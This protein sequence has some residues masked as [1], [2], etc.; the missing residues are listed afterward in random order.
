MKY[1]LFA[2]PSAWRKTAVGSLKPDKGGG[3]RKNAEKF[4]VAYDWTRDLPIL[5]RAMVLLKDKL[6]VAGPPNLWNE[7]TVWNHYRRANS[8]NDAA[9]EQDAAM[10]GLK[11]GTM[12]V[13]SAENG[14]KICES[15]LSSPPAWDGMA[16][17][18][19]CVFMST[20]DGH[21]LC[22]TGK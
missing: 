6:V 3:K 5:V 16:A 15:R 9:R 21:V 8:P 12:M 18:Y 17:A 20:M 19:G 4:H 13:V 14:E 2:A 1:Q 22:F 7:H 11:G 10:A